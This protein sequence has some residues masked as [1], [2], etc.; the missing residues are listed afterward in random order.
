MKVKILKELFNELDGDTDIYIV[1][2]RGPEYQ[3]I[4][5]F[6][7]INSEHPLGLMMHTIDQCDDT[8]KD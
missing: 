4:R 3:E 8:E 7:Y 1:I 5:D 2:Q 6:S